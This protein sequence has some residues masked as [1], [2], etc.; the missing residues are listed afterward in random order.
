MGENFGFFGAK[1]W[2]SSF[3]G[4]VAFLLILKIPP[5]IVALIHHG[6]TFGG[7]AS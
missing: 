1:K 2:N 6:I 4:D 5:I 7:T 3:F